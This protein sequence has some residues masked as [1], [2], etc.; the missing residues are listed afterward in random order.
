MRGATQ[1]TRTTITRRTRR[2]LSPAIRICRRSW[3]S[4][5]TNYDYQ[6]DTQGTVSGDTDLQ[7]KLGLGSG[8]IDDLYSYVNN[9][10][11]AAG[12]IGFPSGLGDVN[13]DGTGDGVDL[14]T[15]AATHLGNVVQIQ[16]PSVNLINR[17]PWDTGTTLQARIEVFTSNLRGQRTTHTDANGNVRVSV[18]Y[19]FN[20]PEGNG[21]IVLPGPTD[22][23]DLAG[24]QYG[25]LKETH[26]DANPDDVFSLVGLDGDLNDFQ[27][28]GPV[29][30]RNNSGIGYLDL[31]TR[32]EGG[33]GAA[34]GRLARRAP[35]I[36]WEI[37]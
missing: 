30:P 33:S 16:R 4:A 25:R 19:P 9:Q 23:P 13:G 36:R 31:V 35:T 15:P 3:A 37:P 22:P 14:T 1:P 26:A 21:G 32:Y 20:D 18:R 10:Y 2:A 24:K 11:T 29:V 7:A 8:D 27:P 34:G 6:K 5:Y 17:V 28:S 12:L